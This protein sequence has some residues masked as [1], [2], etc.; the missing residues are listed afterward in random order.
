MTQK[1]H[2]QKCTVLAHRDLDNSTLFLS[3]ESCFCSKKLVLKAVFT[4]N[5]DIDQG[6]NDIEDEVLEK[7]VN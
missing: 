3:L 7:T 5:R 2:N 1:S 4:C 6:R